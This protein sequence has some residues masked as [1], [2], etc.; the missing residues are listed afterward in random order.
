M[1]YIKILP[2]LV[3]LL[4]SMS[5]SVNAIEEEGFP[6]R[7]KYPSVPFISLQDLY[8]KRNDVVI[9]DTRSKYEHSTLHIKNSINIP[10]SGLDFSSQIRKL[11]KQKKKTIVFYCN[12]HECTKSYDAVIKAKRFAKVEDTLAF[13]AGVFDW[14]R[15]YPSESVLLGKS[16]IKITNL[17]SVEDF[18][19][20]LLK[21]KAFLERSNNKC[22]ILDVRDSAQRTDR[23]FAGYEQSVDLDDTIGIDKYIN[24]AI[25]TKQPLCIYDAVG[26]QVRWLQYYLKQK[27]LKNYFFLDGGA[28]AFFET[29]YKELYGS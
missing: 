9:V 21:P 29:P 2:I 7:A 12:G 6:G 5:F 20:H 11:Y 3:I 26:E 4:S 25:A 23:I 15:K 14:A 13:D 16:P 18:E 19:K 27:N 17:I 8:K 24:E 28:K 10:I 1:R 22:I